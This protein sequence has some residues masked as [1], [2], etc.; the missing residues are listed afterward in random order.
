MSLDLEVSASLQASL[1][2]LAD[3]MR[4]AAARAQSA[5]DHAPKEAPIT[6]H[7]STGST[8]TAVFSCGGPSQGRIWQVRALAIGGQGL[9]AGIARFYAIG[10][11]PLTTRVQVLGCKDSTTF[12]TYPLRTNTYGAHQFIITPMEQLWVV[13]TTATHTVTVQVSGQAEDYDFAAYKAVL[14]L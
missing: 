6:G 3:Q 12:K 9:A 7:G 2:G 14:A 10:A 4:S 8:G 1:D 13:V 11:K 5:L